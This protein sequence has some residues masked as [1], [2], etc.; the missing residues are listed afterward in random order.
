MICSMTSQERLRLR[1]RGGVRRFE[2]SYDA[3]TTN[4]GVRLSSMLHAIE[5]IS[6][7]P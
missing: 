2:L 6:E 5:K 1:P 4:D 7:A 3:P